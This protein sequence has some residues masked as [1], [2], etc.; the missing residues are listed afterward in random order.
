MIRKFLKDVFSS[1]NAFISPN[2][3]SEPVKIRG[4]EGRYDTLYAIMT[5]SGP[6]ESPRHNFDLV[7]ERI[8]DENQ[9]LGTVGSLAE[10]FFDGGT[11]HVHQGFYDR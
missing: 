9:T 3:D 11:R 8:M 10:N 1:I 2:P 7:T 5:I 6:S 4:S